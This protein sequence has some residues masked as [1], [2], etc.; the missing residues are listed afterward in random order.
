MTFKLGLRYLWIDSLCIVQDDLE[1]WRTEGGK[2]AD[3]YAHSYIT[4]AATNSKNSEGGLCDPL[5][6]GELCTIETADGPFK[7]RILQ[8]HRSAP[9]EGY[10]PLTQ[11]AWFFQEQMLAPRIAQSAEYE[12]FWEDVNTTIC[13]CSGSRYSSVRLPRFYHK[14]SHQLRDFNGNERM[15]W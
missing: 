10:M 8:E 14:K 5:P 6:R 1:D 3:I 4:L 9:C 12:P 7:V 11:R 13:E 15:K 2:M